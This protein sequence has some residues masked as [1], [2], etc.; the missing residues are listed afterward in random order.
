M[1]GEYKVKNP[2]LKALY[3]RARLLVAQLDAA[4]FEHIPREL[5]EEA[6]RLSNLGMDDAEA[7][8]QK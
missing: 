1:R 8:A 3:V 2:G 7:H 4:I 6:D 5:N